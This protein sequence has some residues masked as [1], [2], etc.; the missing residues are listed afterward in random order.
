[1]KPVQNI[2]SPAEQ[3]AEQVAVAYCEI[4]ETEAKG[5]MKHLIRIHSLTYGEASA[6][7]HVATCIIH[8]KPWKKDTTN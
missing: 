7:S 2:V 3:M 6:L 8:G 5:L 4:G 1:M